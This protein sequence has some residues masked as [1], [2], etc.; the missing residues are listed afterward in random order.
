M[1][2]DQLKETIDLDQV[3]SVQLT[4][5]SCIV[6]VEDSETKDKLIINGLTL[7][8][9]SVSFL[10]VEKT[11]TNVTIKDMPYEVQNCFVATQMLRYGQVIPESVR[12]GY[13]KGTNIENGSRYLQMLKCDKTLPN[14][15]NFGRFEVRIFADNNRTECKYC[16]TT[17]HPSYLCRDKPARVV[18][19]YNCNKMGHIARDCNNEPVCSFCKQSGHSRNN[20]EQYITEKARRDYGS[21]ASEILEGQ[22]TTQEDA[23]INLNETFHVDRHSLNNNETDQTKSDITKSSGNNVNIILGAS[24]A[25]RLG[26]F[27]QNTINA[28]VSGATLDNVE[29]CISLSTS[30][31]KTPN[32]HIGK[33]ILCLGTNDVTRN[34]DDSDQINITATQA[35]SK[36][37]QT[38][39]KSQ[40]AVCSILP[41]KGRGQHL[42]K[43]NDTSNHVNG[44]LKKM[45]IRDGTLDFIDIHKE[46]SKQGSAIKPLFDTNDVSGVHISSAG[47]EK[48][49]EIFSKY[50]TALPGKSEFP[51]TPQHDKKRNLSDITI[52][53]SSA[54]AKPKHTKAGSP[55]MSGILNR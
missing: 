23:H 47:E 31:I 48:L 36:I 20:C 45:C 40:I 30:K 24:N 18:R 11:I 35:I 32:T 28:S 14:K 33:V 3:K 49:C 55:M 50:L 9:R 42:I 2:I 15:T 51:V 38:F 43:M 12:R 10:D 6:S 5:N 17:D 39:P 26:Q 29:Q 52:S 7:K 25:K 1:I 54:E 4:E 22:Q 16:R 8:N 41:R 46:F 13:I 53:P 37:K 19:C 27:H 21:Y 34:R 44:F